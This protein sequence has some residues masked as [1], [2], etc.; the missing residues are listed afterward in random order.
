MSYPTDAVD[1][2]TMYTYGINNGMAICSVVTGFTSTTPMS[3]KPR[4]LNQVIKI[5]GEGEL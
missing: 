5:M 4:T 3:L 2:A 1:A